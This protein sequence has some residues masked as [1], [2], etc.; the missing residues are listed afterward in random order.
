M[1]IPDNQLTLTFFRLEEDMLDLF[2]PPHHLR[3]QD[4]TVF[5]KLL[6]FKVMLVFP[7]FLITYFIYLD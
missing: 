7:L 5:R 3:L 4:A 6:A 2:F 1:T